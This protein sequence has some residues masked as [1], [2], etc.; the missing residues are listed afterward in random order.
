[1]YTRWTTTHRR[2]LLALNVPLCACGTRGI[3]K[4]IKLHNV[5]DSV[6][7]FRFSICIMGRQKSQ[8]SLGNNRVVR[9]YFTID[10]WMCAKI[11]SYGPYDHI[12][13]V[14]AEYTERVFGFYTQT[15]LDLNFFLC[16]TVNSRKKRPTLYA[17]YSTFANEVAC[18]C[19]LI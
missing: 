18:F 3:S 7:I 12:G 13:S 8:K 17:S 19:W 2:P 14:F 10:F 15:L 9:I 16:F 4:N 5:L 6:K 11:S 1:M